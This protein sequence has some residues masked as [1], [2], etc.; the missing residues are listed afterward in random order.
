MQ[1]QERRAKRQNSAQAANNRVRDVVQLQVQEQTPARGHSAHARLS[2]C[3]EELQAKLDPSDRIAHCRHQCG[4]SR[5]VMSI[6]GAED[7]VR[8]S[9]RHS[10]SELVCAGCS[11]PCRSRPPQAVRLGLCNTVQHFSPSVALVAQRGV[12]RSCCVHCDYG[13]SGDRGIGRLS[14]G[15]TGH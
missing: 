11:T 7:P 2:V 6:D 15:F 10:P 5:I 9:G 14:R 12:G 8:G 1:R 13:R 4:G 3:Q